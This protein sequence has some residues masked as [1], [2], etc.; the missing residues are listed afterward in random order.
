[1][2]RTNG[3][4]LR[5]DA[6]SKGLITR[7]PSDLEDDA[8][9]QFLTAAENVRAEMGEL[10]AAPG[11]E[12]VHLPK[13]KLDS[14]ANL[15]H[16]PNLTSSDEEVETQPIIGTDGQLWTMQKRARTLVCPADPYG[17][18]GDRLKLWTIILSRYPAP[19][20]VVLLVYASD[21]T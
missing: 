6:P 16:Q 4:Q 18:K 14:E 9:A 3:T 17:R 15:I 2:R 19:A 21:V 13:N 5:V 8:K 7:L 1:M 11:Y 10:R 12:R 20:R